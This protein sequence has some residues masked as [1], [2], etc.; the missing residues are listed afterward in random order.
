MRQPIAAGKCSIRIGASIGIA[1]FPEDGLDA[2]SICIA[3]DL[4]MYKKKRASAPCS[5]R[6]TLAS[7]TIQQVLPL[8]AAVSPALHILNES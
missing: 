7:Q 5:A 3:A 1:V 6:E 2:E 8:R 4:R